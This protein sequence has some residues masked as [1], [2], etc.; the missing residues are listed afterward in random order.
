MQLLHLLYAYYFET[1]VVCLKM[2]M[3]CYVY[4]FAAFFTFIAINILSMSIYIY[5]VH[6]ECKC[7]YSFILFCMKHLCVFMSWPEDMDMLWIN[8]LRFV[9]FFCSANLDC[10][11][12][13]HIFK[14]NI[15]WRGT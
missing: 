6:F 12:I 10:L 13:A 1:T 8:F 11:M 15:K 3:F 5:V 9:V 14:T 2:C 4:Y 7:S